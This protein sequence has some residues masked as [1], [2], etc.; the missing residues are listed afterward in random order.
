ML[1]PENQSFNPYLDNTGIRGVKNPVEVSFITADRKLQN[2]KNKKRARKFVILK[3]EALKLSK[4]A[5]NYIKTAKLTP[6][7]RYLFDKIILDTRTCSNYSVFREFNNDKSLQYVHSLKCDNR[8]CPICNSERSK[9]LRKKY[10]EYFDKRPEMFEKYD[11]QHLTL[12]VPHKK[13]GFRGK[14]FY[15]KQIRKEFNLMRKEAFWRQNVYAGEYALEFT[16]NENGLHCHIHALI[17]QRKSLKNRNILHKWILQF[18]NNRTID[19]N[20]LPSPFDVNR[21]AAI[22]KGNKIL[23]ADWVDRHLDSRGST[24]VGLESLY[25]VVDGKKR[26]VSSSSKED[27]FAGIMECLKYHFEP[28]SLKSDITDGFDWELIKEILPEI[29]HMSLYQ[30]FGKF[31]GD[32]ELNFK[33]PMPKRR[34]SESASDYADRVLAWEL[35]KL[36]HLDEMENLEIVHPKS[37]EPME[38][39]EYQFLLINPKNIIM[40]KE[41]DVYIR[42]DRKSVRLPFARN[43]P[44]ALMMAL[45]IKIKNLAYEKR[46]PKEYITSN[47]I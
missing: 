29:Y 44:D 45:S 36:A 8:I 16:K 26:Y 5:S 39:E 14:K 40:S 24:F 13:E 42:K 38:R 21:I 7:E 18:W 46:K 41:N 11:F 35:E 28:F 25:K 10:I 23:T 30:K 43:L 6:D 4:E 34:V 17:L 19:E 22:C 15:M 9:I 37:C 27:M 20:I 47:F 31:Y 33:N 12:T 32:K 2:D 1:T 3:H